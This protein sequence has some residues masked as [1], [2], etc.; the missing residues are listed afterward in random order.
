MRL[1]RLILPQGKLLTEFLEAFMARYSYTIFFGI[2]IGL[3]CFALWLSI[4]LVFVT[5]SLP[6]CILLVSV[7]P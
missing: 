5:V 2:N 4:F 3:S 6:N 1:R 7:T